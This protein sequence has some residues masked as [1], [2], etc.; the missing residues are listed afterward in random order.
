V[1]NIKQT[2]TSRAFLF[3]CSRKQNPVEPAGCQ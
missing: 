1:V 3:A 2:S